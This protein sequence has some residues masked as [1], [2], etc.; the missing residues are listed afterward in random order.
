MNIKTK[1]PRFLKT[2]SGQT[3]PIKVVKETI[4]AY[5]CILGVN[6]PK[7]IR[8]RKKNSHKLIF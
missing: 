1:K 7:S 6:P 8:I 2:D 4:C 5:R 3:I